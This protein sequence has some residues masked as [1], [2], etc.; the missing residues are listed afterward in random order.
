M[1]K[2]WGRRTSSNVQKVMWTVAELGLA[3]E[4]IDLGGPFG[5]N[6]EPAYQALNPNGLVPT[7]VD[8]DLVL[9]ESNSIVRYLAGRYGP[10]PLEPAD[11]KMRALANQW[12]DWQLSVVAPAISPAFWG[13]VRTPPEAR[14]LAAISASQ[15][16][17]SEVLGIFDQALGRQLYAAGPDFSMGD[18]PL[19]V[20]VYRFYHLVP[21]PPKFPN[22]ARWYGAIASRPAFVEHVSSIPLQ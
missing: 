19:G 4:R 13:L 6:R 3:H 14:D 8:D 7:L 1:S 22:L 11:L 15:R 5:G 10:G 16:K 2:I 20:M 18:V 21:E 17:T 9:W 12:M